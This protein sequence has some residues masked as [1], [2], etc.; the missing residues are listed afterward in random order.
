MNSFWGAM[1]GSAIGTIT[2]VVGAGLL[3]WWYLGI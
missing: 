1:L 3:L 2:T